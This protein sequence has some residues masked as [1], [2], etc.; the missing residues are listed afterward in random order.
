MASSDAAS[1]GRQL[2]CNDRPQSLQTLLVFVVQPKDIEQARRVAD[3]TSATE[4]SEKI[5]IQ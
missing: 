4:G 1:P 3:R 2:H 5:I